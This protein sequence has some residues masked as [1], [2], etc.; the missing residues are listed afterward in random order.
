MAQ[1]RSVRDKAIVL[2]MLQGGL[3]P[4]E[5]LGLRLEDVAYGRRRVVVRR[6]EDHPKGARSKSRYERA[7]AAA[8]LA[9]RAGCVSSTLLARERANSLGGSMES[10]V[11]FDA[12][13][14]DYEKALK[15]MAPVTDAL[16]SH[17]PDLT[18]DASVLDI[19]C[20]T[21]EPGLSLLR[22]S[23]GLQLLGIDSSSAMVEMARRRSETEGLGGAR[24]AVMDAQHLDVPPASVDVIVSRFGALS[25]GDPVRGAEEAVRVLRSGGSVAVAVWD[26]LSK[27]ILVHAMATALGDHTPPG[28]RAMLDNLEQLAMPGL[29]ESYLRD[30]GLSTV[31]SELFP[32]TSDFSDEATMWAFMCAPG[33]FQQPVDTLD[34]GQRAQVRARFGELLADHRRTDGSFALPYG[35]RLIWGRR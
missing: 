27:N 6:R 2:L 8:R 19:A 24:F 28:V 21:G 31:D 29:R 9:G 15:F 17:L 3:R 23:P 7:G 20:G 22:R 5:T 11:D 10:A 14:A 12:M 16:L 32:W 26:V 1:L 18:G 30:A 4:G 33:L 13:A 25:F 35:C 34:E